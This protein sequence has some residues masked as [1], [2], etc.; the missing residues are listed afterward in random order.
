MRE[1]H[2]AASRAADG[3]LEPDGAEAL[4]LVENQES[5]VLGRGE[6]LL[7]GEAE[8]LDACG[9]EGRIPICVVSEAGPVPVLRTVDL[10]GEPEGG[11]EEV[12]R[13][14][15]GR[16]LPPE[17]GSKVAIPQDIPDA[18]LGIRRGDA[19]EAAKVDRR[20]SRIAHGESL[21]PGCDAP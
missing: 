17:L 2:V 13:V 1:Q 14:A 3:R 12:E 16:R 11:A 8:D 20:K 10:D 4:D 18:R 6:G 9:S 21:S 15:A 7:V 19:L 5:D